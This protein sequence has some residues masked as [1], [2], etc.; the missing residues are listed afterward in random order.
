MCDVDDSTQ[1]TLDALQR[2]TL[3]YFLHEANPGNGLVRDNT[4]AGAPSSITAVGFALAAYVVGVERGWMARADAIA[5]VLATLRFFRDAPSSDAK[6]ATGHCGFYY[7]FLD[8]ESGRRAGKCEL[9]TIDTTF[10]VAGALAT[11]SYF[12]AESGDEREIRALADALYRRVDWQWALNGG[13]TVS[14]GWKPESGF[15]KARW[16]GYNEAILLYALGMGSPSHPLP[17]GSYEAWTRSYR[18]KSVGGAEYL[19]AGPLFIHQFSHCWIDFRGIQDDYMSARGSD[20]F[21]NSRRATIAQ[22][23]YAMRNAKRFAG[24]GEHCWGI[25]ASDGPGPSRHHIDGRER[26]F[27]EY[28]ARGIPYG[29][30]DGTIAPWVAVASLP[31]APEIVLPTI[32][33]LRLTYPRATELYGFRSAFNPTFPNG[34][35]SDRWFGIDQG[36]VVLMI[37]NFRSALTWQLMK[38]CPYLV[39]GLR[40]AGFRNGW[41]SARD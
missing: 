27:K 15:L 23:R 29:F 11:A 2:D 26:R 18:W 8:M 32:R 40:R 36:P 30:D 3:A 28:A 10:L 41:L 7:H 39:A 24:Y 37:E 21:E 5:R 31:F 9:S 34:W 19:Y 33:Q 38:Q 16:E 20:Y 12:T 35:Y 4:R 6:D 17:D 22:Q 25:T 14:H 13:V 1:P